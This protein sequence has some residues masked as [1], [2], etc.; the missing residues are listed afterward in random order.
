MLESLTINRSFNEGFAPSDLEI[1][2][3]FVKG[4]TRPRRPLSH[5]KRPVPELGG[6]AIVADSRSLRTCI[7]TISTAS[8]NPL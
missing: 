7:T 4:T 8:E 6:G 5:R 2:Q 1:D 3:P